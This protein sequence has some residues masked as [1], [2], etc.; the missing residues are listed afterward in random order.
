MIAVHAPP[1]SRSD[2]AVHGTNSARR[3]L[4]P[5]FGF[6]SIRPVTVPPP[7]TPNCASQRPAPRT[8]A[9]LLL[10]AAHV[11]FPLARSAPAQV[12]ATT[13]PNP[14]SSTA[15]SAPAI[16]GRDFAG[17][18]LSAPV[19]TGGLQLAAQRATYWN[20]EPPPG[21]TPGTTIG[22]PVQRVLL[23]GDVRVGLGVYRFTA[24]RA[25]VWIERLEPSRSAPGEFLQQVAIYFDRVSDP[26]AQAGSSQAGDRLLVTG[27]V[28]GPVT[29]A[30]D[31]S[32]PTPATGPLVDE[33][34]RRLAA[35]LADLL[36][37]AD[38]PVQRDDLR[39]DPATARPAP[40][41]VRAPITPG[42]SQP[43]EPNSPLARAAELRGAQQ[44]PDPRGPIPPA[45]RLPAIFA[46]EGIITFAAGEPTLVP[47]QD[48]AENTII[49]TGG[50]TVQY[51]D[52]R[53]DRQL[54]I[55]AERCVAFLEAGPIT[56]LFRSPADKVI[57]I[58]AE[59]NVVAT[60]GRYTLR[61]PQVYYDVRANRAVLIDAVF[62]TYDE[63][64]GLPLYVRAKTI[65]QTA[66]NQIQ[67]QGVTLANSSF[68]EPHLSVGATSITVTREERP[69]D[70][71]G[72]RTLVDGR[73]L[74]LRAGRLPFFYYPRYD[75]EVE[76]FP[77]REV[78]FENSSDSGAG[79]KTS[80]DLFGL[81][82]VDAPANTRAEFLLDAYLKRGVAVG[83]EGRYA[84]SDTAGSFLAYLVPNDQ[85]RDQL[86][87]GERKD[88]DGETRGLLLAEHRWSIDDLWTVFAEGAYVSDENFV[89]AYYEPLAETRREFTTGLYLR[90]L[91]EQSLLSLQAKG[92]L[93]NFTPNEYLL[94]SQGYDVDKLPEV[95]Y[96]RVQDDLLAEVQPGLLAWSQDYRVGY[97]SLN[98]TEKTPQDLG[99]FTNPAAQ[100]AFGLNRNQ[101][102]S[103][104]L[105][106]RGFIDDG[107]LRFD[108]RHELSSQLHVGPVNITPFA[109]GRLTTY[110]TDF[111]AFRT[112]AG[113][114]ETE[115]TRLYGALG[116]RVATSLQHVDDAV[117]NRFFD[118]H[119]TRHIIEPSI[120]AWTSGTNVTQGALPVYDQSVE[121]LADGSAVRLGVAQTWQ[122][123]RGGEGRWRSVD[124]LK[125]NTDVVYSSQDAD[126]ESPL[127]RFFDYRPEYSLLGDFANIDAAWQVTDATGLVFA[128]IYDLDIHQP[129]RTTAGGVIQHSGD[130]STFA[131]MHYLNARDST[132]VTFGADYRFTQKYTIG[133][134]ATYDVDLR[135]FQELAFRINREFPSAILSL[136][137]RY[138]NITD[139]VALGLVI[140]PAGRDP[141]RQQLQRL[142]RDQFDVGEIPEGAIQSEGS[143]P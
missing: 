18:R 49:I 89:D 88:R 24:A 54:Q 34:Q 58:Y 112:A 62:W 127:K 12:Q 83:A 40:A 104:A 35:L 69:A 84:G 56:E 71:G 94:Q 141:R 73:D 80:W 114:N 47:G 102:L 125:V 21:P 75:G 41:D 11:A 52:Q 17:V 37:P 1:R 87:S 55:S 142:G 76:R 27:L 92:N 57:G 74:T 108:T 95:R 106:A 13:A 44:P 138:N 91:D 2:A 25:V 7:I 98:F 66:R 20:Q 9:A 116:V 131:E 39:P 5:R 64:R 72:P 28:E 33:A 124:V 23:E 32:R 45:E 113:A 130:F 67:A 136:K 3:K 96:A 53:Q 99:Y 82:G 38:Q 140:Q 90:R 16:D 78:A 31:S 8:A 68:F 121:S 105:L 109:V 36:A 137:L 59:G 86:T 29:L 134:N 4:C 48:G 122:T 50:V 79:I 97:M 70:Q 135:D 110:D 61:G 19:Q 77:L 6:R 143:F 123:Y 129:A 111:E 115:Q 15:I 103:D 119:R 63:R 132:F 65:K 42:M 120:T 133:A 126:R 139:E 46:R 85:G 14:A 30:A 100:A 43:F 60:D 128:Q 26:A 117:D 118:L 81:F 10:L 107:V 101:R 22:G 51:T 93:N